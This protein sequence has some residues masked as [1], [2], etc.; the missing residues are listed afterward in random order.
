MYAFHGLGEIDVWTFS[1]QASQIAAWMVMDELVGWCVQE[2]GS[3]LAVKYGARKW[4]PGYQP[5]LCCLVAWVDA[6]PPSPVT[7]IAI[8]STFG[9]CVLVLWFVSTL[10]VKKRILDIV[11]CNL[12][13]DCQFLIIFGTN[14]LDTA[15]QQVTFNFPPNSMSVSTLPGQNRTN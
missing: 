9:L 15:G 11:N 8:N 14:I 10:C 2:S 1:H 4:S 12:N 6:E 5:E 7:S 13:K 3:T